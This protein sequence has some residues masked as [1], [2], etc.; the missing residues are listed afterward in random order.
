MNYDEAGFSRRGRLLSEIPSQDL[1]S[2]LGVRTVQLK[3]TPEGN[4][5]EP[6]KVVYL[7]KKEEKNLMD[8]EAEGLLKN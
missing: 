2:R 7:E 6:A 5:T 1:K 8:G 3:V 4:H